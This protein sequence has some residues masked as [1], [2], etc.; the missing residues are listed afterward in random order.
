MF[1][2]FLLSNLC[3]RSHRVPVGTRPL[4]LHQAKVTAVVWMARCNS[5]KVTCSC[6]LASWV[7]CMYSSHTKCKKN[8]VT[9]YWRCLHGIL[10]LD[11]YFIMVNSQLTCTDYM[12]AARCIVCALWEKLCQMKNCPPS[13]GEPTGQE[14]VFH[15]PHHQV[16]ADKIYLFVN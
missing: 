13:T 1:R 12:M 16:C 9:C 10:D 5:P 7:S 8:S 15:F 4:R 14:F 6:A 2:R 11:E 3:H